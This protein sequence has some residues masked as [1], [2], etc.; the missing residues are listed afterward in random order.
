MRILHLVTLMSSDGAYGGPLRVAL[1]QAAE[2]NRRGH[3]V[4]IAAGWR[5]EGAPPRSIDRVTLHLFPAMQLY[6]PLRFSGMVSPGLIWWLIN[7][8]D[9]FDL[10]HIHAARDLISTASL[11]IAWARRRPYVT[12]THGMIQ[13]DER[14]LVRILDAMA[15][16]ALLRRAYIRFVLTEREQ[17][18]LT[19][20]LGRFAECVRLPNGVPQTHISAMS[21]TGCQVLFCARL[22]R[23]KRPTAFVEMA[24]EL[25]RHGVDANFALVGPDDGELRAV[26][27]VIAE[28]GLEASVR[29][30]GPLDYSAVLARMAQ[31]DVYVL[32]SVDEPFPMSLLEAMSLG[33]PS[34]CTDSCGL[35][36]V[37]REY[38][39][40]IVTDGT[41]N[42][43]TSAVQSLLTS[44]SLRSELTS[45]ALRMIEEKFSMHAIGHQL[46]KAYEECVHSAGPRNDGIGNEVLVRSPGKI[47]SENNVRLPKKSDAYRRRQSRLAGP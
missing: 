47:S 20:V 22:H 33:L 29:Y 41:V 36:G 3:E 43:L 45:N 11:G 25:L 2:L 28:N 5:G 6:K 44:A 24:A 39:A 13:P 42:A 17:E 46:Q 10:L 4:H 40:A 19:S 14:F 35:S 15:M 12:Q 7:N 27:Q 38:R 9:Q 23:R 32:P 31:A 16:R 1:N 18:G 30:E 21:R 8:V 37:L 26:R 34:V